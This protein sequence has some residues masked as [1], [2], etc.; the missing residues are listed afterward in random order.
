[1]YRR[2]SP[3][4]RFPSTVREKGPSLICA[5]LCLPFVVLN[6][7][8]AAATVQNSYAYGVWGEFFPLK[9]ICRVL[10]LDARRTLSIP[11]YEE[12]SPRSSSQ[13]PHEV[14]DNDGC[15]HRRRT[16]DAGYFGEVRGE[17]NKTFDARFHDGMV[18]AAGTG[19]ISFA[20]RPFSWPL[21]VSSRSS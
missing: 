13:K 21:L 10:F 1:V 4:E 6:G 15:N 2:D 19:V 9:T 5:Q 3:S 7:F 16:S 20:L 11:C 17:K 12:G 8:A 18:I 14:V